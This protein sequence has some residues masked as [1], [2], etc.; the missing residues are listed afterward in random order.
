MAESEV[1]K[2][3]WEAA[4]IE[5]MVGRRG[6]GDEAEAVEKLVDI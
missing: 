1:A 5:E 2:F 6:A 3:T 4:M